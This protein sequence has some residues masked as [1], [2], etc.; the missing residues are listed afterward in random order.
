RAHAVSGATGSV[1][2]LG[3]LLGCDRLAAGRPGVLPAVGRA[4]RDRLLQLAGPA[5]PGG[6]PR[7]AVRKR[8]AADPVLLRLVDRLLPALVPPAR[9]RAHRLPARRG[10]MRGLGVHHGKR[11]FPLRPR[12]CS[13]RPRGCPL[14]R[15]GEPYPHCWRWTSALTAIAGI[16]PARSSWPSKAG[17]T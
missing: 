12:G 14:R 3:L 6:L 4:E 15:A 5:R 7:L 16:W 11:S 10:E 2:G 1:R 9:S 8:R 13:L 17:D